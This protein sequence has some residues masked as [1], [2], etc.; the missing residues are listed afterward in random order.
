MKLYT[1]WRSSAAYR[2]R[3]ALA[4]K[5]VAFDSVPVSL[6]PD[7]LEQ[8]DPAYRALNPEMRLPSLELDD[9]RVVGQSMAMLEWIEETWPEPALLPADAWGRA[10]VRAVCQA[11][12][13]DTHPLQNSSVLA[14][15]RERFGADDAAVRD[16]ARHWIGRGLLACEARAAGRQ[17]TFLFGETP[18]LADVCLVPQMYNARRFGVDLAALPR[19]A[20]V[21][22]RCTELA[23][24]R[25]AAPEVQPDAP[26]AD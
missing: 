16:W 10:E 5:G 13:S 1:Y 26:A 17:T 9:G 22:A 25:S 6:H 19:L 2:V 8:Y 15:L 11:I 12:V 20:A 24:F 7:R 14:A 21:E 4:L 18:G 3:I 23:A